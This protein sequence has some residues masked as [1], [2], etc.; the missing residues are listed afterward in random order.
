M[1]PPQ[2]KR[3]LSILICTTL[4][5]FLASML[6][7]LP[8]QAA[9]TIFVNDSVIGGNNDG[10]DWGNA[11]SDLQDALSVATDGS[12][13][14][15]AKGVYVP[16]NTVTHTFN[17]TDGVA[18][19]GG[20][21]A[22]E[23]L[24]TERNWKDN[25]TVLSGDI[26]TN[27]LKTAASVTSNINGNNSTHI[28]TS[29]GVTNT[30][31][32]D[33]FTITGGQANKGYNC[34]TNC[35]GGMSNVNGSPTLNNLLFITNIATGIG[36]GMFNEDHSNPVLTNVAFTGNFAAW[37]G[38]G[39]ANRF[40]SNPVLINVSFSGNSAFHGAGMVNE[41]SSPTLINVSFS[42]NFAHGFEEANNGRGGGMLNFGFS[43]PRITNSIFWNNVAGI[44][45]NISNNITSTI[46]STPT[47]SYS[48]IEGS[49][50]S[51]NIGGT[52]NSVFGIDGGNNIDTDPLFVTPIDASQA[53][54]TKG[55][56]QLQ[57]GSPAIDVG[58]TISYTD[59]TS[60]TTDLAENQRIQNV[61][62]D[63]GAYEFTFIEL[64][65]ATT[66]TGTGNVTSIPAGI[67]CGITCTKLFAASTP[68]TLTAT[69]DKN[70][71]FT[72]W[73]GWPDA[74]EGTGPCVV[75]M[76]Q[77]TTA[78]ATFHISYPLTTTTTGSGIGN[79]A[80]SPNAIS[81]THGTTV[82][83]TP[84]ADISSTFTN[85]SGACTGSADCVVTMEMA[86]MVT[87]TFTIKSYALTTATTGTGSGSIARS[88]N[89]VTYT[90][91]TLVTL[92]PTAVNGSTF[93]GWSGACTGTGPCT[94]TMDNAKTVT[95]T[96]HVS[97]AL[98]STMSGSGSGSVIKSPNFATH[99]HGTTV[100]LSAVANSNSTFT[101]WSGAGCTGTANC[102]V[103]MDAAKSVDAIFTIKSYALTTATSGAGNGSIMRS[104]NAATYG[105]G[106]KVTLTVVADSGSLF[107]GW[108]GAGCS[109]VGS[110]IVT[111]DS[112]KSVAA[113]FN[114]IIY[115]P[116]I[117]TSD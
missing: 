52:W 116:I 26:D 58:Q 38:G 97:Y 40:D 102:V 15:V 36:G 50:G 53:P 104:P 115:L 113:S 109:G 16:G 106:T 94:V 45:P 60:A 91:G 83:L 41:I 92:T 11:Y 72:G 69:A 73:S 80:R 57:V 47:I 9:G 7:S 34:L 98:T 46:N 43:N 81:Y 44:G 78:I 25:I 35:G 77:V 114:T 21:S 88:P 107:M 29:R 95:A 6:F 66:G 14:W 20:F 74:C 49:G 103:T 27:D 63:M 17:L 22:T 54:T 76:D 64:T 82:T 67:D 90:H 71:T 84:I 19:F 89:A 10:T 3:I 56:A 37:Q 117:M 48:L 100:T 59:V 79:I 55:S 33:G 85:W 62:I 112:A 8:V 110:C 75:T 99:V 23:T 101:G 28:V 68:V 31:I 1:T 2:R 87:A 4:L 65:V 51:D 42:G 12:E 32:L 105:H 86:N 61:I 108:S 18:I 30:A 111:M 70:F 5:F 39:M 24:R 96:F 93:T 13:I